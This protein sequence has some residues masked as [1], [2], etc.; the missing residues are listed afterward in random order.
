MA[1]GEQVIFSNPQ[2]AWN[3]DIKNNQLDNLNNNDV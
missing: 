3:I 2:K 1:L